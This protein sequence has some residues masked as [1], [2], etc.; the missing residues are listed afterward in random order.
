MTVD[1]L[2]VKAER[3]AKGYTQSDVAK[4]MGLNRVQY[5]KRESGRISFSADELIKLTYILGYDENTIG[6]FFKKDVPEK[7]Q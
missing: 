7:Q 1:L 4:L 6:I 5:S 2:R 3:V